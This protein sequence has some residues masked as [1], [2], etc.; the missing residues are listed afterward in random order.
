[1]LR[2]IERARDGR[3]I[4]EGKCEMIWAREQVYAKACKCM[5]YGPSDIRSI[6]FTVGNSKRTLDFICSEDEATELKRAYDERVACQKLVSGQEDLVRRQWLMRRDVGIEVASD[7]MSLTWAD[8][9]AA[10]AMAVQDGLKLEEVLA[11]I[12]K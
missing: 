6:G 9:L 12:A 1:M 3:I 5:H 2:F 4:A 10:E 8:L 7:F 11:V